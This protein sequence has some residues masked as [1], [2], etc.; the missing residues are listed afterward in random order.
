MDPN[1]LHTKVFSTGLKPSLDPKGVAV[2]ESRDSPNHPESNA[3]GVL[4]DVTGSMGEIPKQFA[5]Q[6]LGNLMT[7]L[8]SKGVIP[9][10]QVLIGAIGDARHDDVPFQIGQFESGLEMDQCLTDIFLE[11]KGGGNGGESYGQ[12]H[13]FFANH[14]SIDCFEKRGKKGYLFTIGDEPVHERLSV[15][16]IKAVFGDTIE[17]DLNVTDLIRACQAKYEVFHI[18]VNRHSYDYDRVMTQWKGL[19]G[20]RVLQLSNPDDI[21]DLIVATIGLCEGS[22]LDAVSSVLKGAGSS[23]STVHSVQ[24][25]LAPLVSSAV[26][27]AGSGAIVG[28]LP[29]SG[30]AGGTVRL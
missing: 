14:T 29:T 27:K 2:R 13:Y 8:V 4:F 15:A 12:A 11:G 26:V 3:I 17:A 5:T 6:K 16:E 7:L 28:T 24:T 1:T 19:L 22:T 18:V 21:C 20:E 30:D 10:P 23:A 9:H 25:A